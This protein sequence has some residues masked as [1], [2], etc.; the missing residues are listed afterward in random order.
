MDAKVPN[1]VEKLRKISTR[2]FTSITDR[3]Q[4]DGRA[5]A[6]SECERESFAKN[7]LCVY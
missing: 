4:R 3:W 5:T 2:G 1:A 7:Q 6:H